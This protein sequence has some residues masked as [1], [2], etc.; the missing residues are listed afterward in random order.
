MSRKCST[1]VCVAVQ[2]ILPGGSEQIFDGSYDLLLPLT[3]VSARQDRLVEYDRNAAKRTAVIDDQS[4][5]FEIDSNAWLTDEVHTTSQRNE[6]CTAHPWAAKTGFRV[7]GS[8]K[9]LRVKMST[10]CTAIV[11]L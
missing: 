7:Q 6:T 5:F 9:V 10:L 3:S 4:D 11:S 8:H 1:S 2:L